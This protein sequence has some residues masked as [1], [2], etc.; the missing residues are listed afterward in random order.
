MKKKFL[1]P[2][3]AMIF[4]AGMAFATADSTVDNPQTKYV[5]V[6]G[7]WHAIQESD[8]NCGIG[9]AECLVMF[10]EDPNS[11]TYQVYHSENDTDPVRGGGNITVLE[12]PVPTN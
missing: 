9:S 1:L 2:M 6:N 4:A 3:L 11:N 10:E 12:G 5:D 8:L 7:T